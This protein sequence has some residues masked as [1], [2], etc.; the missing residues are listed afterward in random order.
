VS[1]DCIPGS[2]GCSELRIKGDS[3]FV[4][5]SGSP[6]PFS[7]FADPCIRK[8]PKAPFLWLT[9]SWPNYHF[10]NGSQIPT[11][12]THLA[13][14]A[15]GGNTWEFV[16]SLWPSSPLTNPADAS[17]PGYLNNEASNILPVAKGDSVTWYAVRLNYLMLAQGGTNARPINSFHIRVF[18]ATSPEALDSSPS[19][20]LGTSMT[21]PTWGVNQNLSLLAPELNDV[22]LWNE[23]ALFFENDTLYLALVSFVYDANGQPLMDK[24]GVY[25]F[26]TVPT[27]VP[28]G[29]RWSFRGKLAGSSEAQELGGQRLSQ[30]D[31][32]RSSSGT[33]MLVCTPDDWIPALSDYNHKGCD[34][35]AIRSLSKPELVRDASNKLTVLARVTAS[36]AGPLGSAASAYDANSSTGIL[37]TRRIKSTTEFTVSVWRTS[38]QPLKGATDVRLQPASHELT[39]QLKQNFPNPFNPTTIISY[40]VSAVSM[41][42]LVIYDVLGREVS[43]LV[44]GE[45]QPGVHSV[46]WD[47]TSLSSGVY[48]YRLQARASGGQQGE[49]AYTKA[50]VFTK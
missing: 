15:D 24:H 42:T 26:S 47:A 8:D 3:A 18:K 37:F 17:Q 32:A 19:A 43:T 44:N 40:Q 28:A 31:I 16:K 33:L 41:V 2:Q 30:V 6:S 5:P 25:V 29:W 50:M 46:K 21:S 23:P 1:V 9:Y 13:K 14:S 20:I 27:G 12:D 36:D 22:G 4:L 11:V 45:V 48:L 39:F 49:I 34:V 7:G 35:L 38:L 10:A